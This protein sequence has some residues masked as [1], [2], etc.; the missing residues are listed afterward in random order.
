MDLSPPLAVTR[1]VAPV[2]QQVLSNIRRAIFEGRFKPGDRL[3]ERELC[4][5]T[6]VGRSSIREALRQLETEGLIVTQPNRGPVVRTISAAE[7]EDLYQVRA[8]LEALAGK[9]FA[10]RA[11]DEAID[12]LS[13]AVDRLEA[14]VLSGESSEVRGAVD[15]FYDV[16]LGGCGSQAIESMLRS[17]HNRIAV[18]R[19]TTL[20]QPERPAGG[21]AELRAIVT[22]IGS[23]DLD[24]A[25]RACTEHVERAGAAAL[26][27]L[28]QSTV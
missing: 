8:V 24:A 16:L 15:A 19:A 11:Q 27:T 13:G 17:L 1:T 10:M 26:R 9:L 5:L 2:R 12:A 18:L 28:G 22:A 4:A 14:A 7:A 20:R 3:I 25:S 23:R 6:G 21:L